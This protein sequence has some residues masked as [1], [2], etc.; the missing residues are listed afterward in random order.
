MATPS[1][2][3]PWDFF[4]HGEDFGEFVD[5]LRQLMQHLDYRRNPIFRGR[6]TQTLDQESW[7]MEVFLYA[8]EGEFIAHTFRPAIPQ[9]SCEAAVQDAARFTCT[10]LTQMHEDLLI[11]TPFHYFQ[12][13]Q[14]GEFEHEIFVVMLV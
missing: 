9:S 4:S 14:E 8:R 2:D 10:R 5:I 6:K 12:P 3:G 11:E 1:S 13:L 7:A